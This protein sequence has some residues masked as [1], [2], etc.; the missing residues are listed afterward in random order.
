MEHKGEWDMIITIVGAGGKTTVSGRLGSQL[1]QQGRSVLFTTTTHI[2]RPSDIPVFTGEAKNIQ[3]LAPYMAAAKE[4]DEDGKLKGF[5]PEDID[6]LDQKHLFDIIIVEGDGSKGLP[7]KAP[8]EWEPMFPIS[9]KLAIG[10]IGLDCLG[11]PVTEEFV[12]RPGLFCTVTGAKARELI[13]CA[14]LLALIQSP[15]GLFRHAPPQAEKVIFLNKADLIGNREQLSGQ[16]KEAGIPVFLTSRDTDW[17]DD[18][19]A[20]FIPNQKA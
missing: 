20:G 5:A 14:H 12:H 10:L 2:R 6:V 18:F 4:E 15:M 19:I 16:M 17:P 3:L 11:K 9:T 8:A 13:T 1:A 7:V